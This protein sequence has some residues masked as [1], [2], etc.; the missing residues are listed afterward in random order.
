M[1]CSHLASD[2]ALLVS[3]KLLLP[4]EMER[5]LPPLILSIV[6]DLSL[7]ASTRSSHASSDS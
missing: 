6:P 4:A 5:L 1:A 3:P 2:L 7:A